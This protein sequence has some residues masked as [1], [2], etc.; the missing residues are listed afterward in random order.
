MDSSGLRDRV[1]WIVVACGLSV[2]AAPS[3]DSE[4][5][6]QVVEKSAGTSESGEANQKV[7]PEK[8]KKKKDSPPEMKPG[9]RATVSGPVRAEIDGPSVLRKHAGPS[10]K[11][12]I[13]LAQL[14]TGEDESDD[15]VM[16][17][18]SELEMNQT[19]THLPNAVKAYF[20]KVNLACTHP[21][22]GDAGGE[23]SFEVEFERVTESSIQGTFSGTLR[24]EPTENEKEEVE[25]KFVDVEGEFSDR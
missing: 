16:F 21:V 2:A 19:E 17:T 12:Q 7:S 13:V 15:R 20:D 18:V 14:P 6:D 23:T 11:K 10:G 25:P 4:S 24:C 3:C 22:A 9:W 1:G 8:K 5:G